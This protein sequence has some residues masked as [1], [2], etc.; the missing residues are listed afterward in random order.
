[1]V[2]E[3]IQ[4]KIV[5]DDG[6][7]RAAFGRVSN[8]MEQIIRNQIKMRNI[9]LQMSAIGAKAGDYPEYQRLAQLNS[10][11]GLTKKL[12]DLELKRRRETERFNFSWLSVLFTGMAINRM[13]AQ[14]VTRVTDM[15]GITELFNT[16]MSLLTINALMPALPTIYKLLGA[17]VEWSAKDGPLQKLVAGLIV[18]GYALGGFMQAAGQIG[19]AIQGFSVLPGAVKSLYALSVAAWANV[20]PFV[21]LG[22][23]VG[24]LL[25]GATALYL[26]LTYIAQKIRDIINGLNSL[27]NMRFGDVLDAYTSMTPGYRMASSLGVRPVNLTV[28]A[29]GTY[30]DE[31]QNRRLGDTIAGTIIDTLYTAKER[32]LG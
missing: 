7:A 5:A 9:A 19:M 21:I 22:I 31:F 29:N 26:V 18:G 6:S 23:Q 10:K 16:G 27:K 12:G 11:L 3:R 4:F 14:Y 13:F 32:V 1:M 8:I 24:I 20:P 2:E 25:A 17:F 30:Q 15:L 28:N